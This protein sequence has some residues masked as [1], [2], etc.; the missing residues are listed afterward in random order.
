MTIPSKDP[1]REEAPASPLPGLVGGSMAFRVLVRDVETLLADPPPVILL[2]GETGTGKTLLARAIHLRSRPR[3]SPFLILPCASLPPEVIETEIFGDV[4]DASDRSSGGPPGERLDRGDGLLTLAGKGTL[5]L[6]D[7]DQLPP[8]I[9]TRLRTRLS[10]DASHR[11][12]VVATTRVPEHEAAGVTDLHGLAA[13]WIADQCVIVPPLRRRM[14]DLPLLVEQVLD[15]WSRA[16]DLA[17]PQLEEGA[18]EALRT[19]PWPGNLRELKITLENAAGI[20]PGGFIRDEH[21]RIRTRDTRPL[22]DDIDAAPEMIRIPSDGK[23]WD[24]IEAEAVA[25]T[26]ELTSWNR[27]QASRLLGVS[28]PTLTRKIKKY[29]LEAPSGDE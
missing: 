12:Q 21:L 22:A 16:E 13:P 11:P 8:R 18:M 25:A 6:E 4:P 5:V 1:L 27:S 24:A 15:N 2:R 23:A 29:G 14:D 3:G 20:V 7:A 17:S 19:H 26:L 10:D 28:R 9:F